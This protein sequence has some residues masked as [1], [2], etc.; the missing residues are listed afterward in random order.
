M[1]KEELH[2]KA[3]EAL[4]SAAEKL[5]GMLVQE[6]L[7]INTEGGPFGT[8]KH[9]GETITDADMVGEPL[10]GW[11][12]S[13]GRMVGRYFVL[14][15]R[16]IALKGEDYVELRRL[17]DRALRTK[18]FRECLSPTFV[19]DE[20]FIWC[21]ARFR[22]ERKENFS[23]Y[24]LHRV[25]EEVRAHHIFVPIASIEI[26]R[27][28][29]LGDVR[30]LTLSS[31]FFDKALAHSVARVPEDAKQHVVRHFEKLKRK[32]VGSTAIEIVL[33]GEKQFVED[34]A[35]STAS[36]MAAVL[37][38]LSPPALSATIAFPCY[39]TGEE[40]A[41]ARTIFEKVE[42]DGIATHSALL[43]SAMYNYRMPFAELDEKMK[44]GLGNLA[45]FFRSHS[46]TEHQKRVRGALLAYSRGVGSYDPNDRLLYAMTAAEHL[47]LRDA[48]EP[49]QGNVGERMAFVIS[50]APDDR[51]AVV[52]T[53]KRAYQLRSQYVHHLV[54]VEDDE[55]LQAFFRNM[56]VLLF[57]AVANMMKFDSQSDFLDAIDRVKFS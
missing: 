18:P 25:K 35:Y 51:K 57:T 19:E 55:A 2:P 44:G 29:K 11:S 9:V 32:H 4:D 37:R 6:P 26:E 14:K 10:L 16:Q 42:G 50:K 5:V 1:S 47:L 38:F 49:I 7:D 43:H 12:D 52:S 17:A 24:L 34:Q 40:H 15:R 54:S 23:S 56:W 30:V 21:R 3:A 20:I 28:F 8:R 46:L 39:P 27:P 36:D 31:E 33:T 22:G 48:S 41:P 45:L 13:S 53:F